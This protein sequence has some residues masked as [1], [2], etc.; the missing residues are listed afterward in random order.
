MSEGIRIYLT[1][2]CEGFDKLRDALAQQ[3]GIVVVGSAQQVVDAAGALQGGHLDC[4]L[5]GTSSSTL[6][7]HEIAAI[8]ELTRVPLL[9]LASGE[10]SALL[11]EALGADV[12]DVV[13]LRR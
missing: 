12:A 9:V 13:L 10:S 5:H 4:V 11:E 8:R 3:P 6:P 1:G 7:A 2:S